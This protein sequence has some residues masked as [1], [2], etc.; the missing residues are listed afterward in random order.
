MCALK[1]STASGM[2]STS[3]SVSQAIRLARVE[4]KKNFHHSLAS[5]CI[6]KRY[7]RTYKVGVIWR[8]PIDR[9]AD[10]LKI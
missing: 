9:P 4:R 5:V 7:V 2:Y 8:R 6:A 3:Q 10:R 1:T